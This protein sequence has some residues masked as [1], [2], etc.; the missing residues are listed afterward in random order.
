MSL[1][2]ML[3]ED[4]KKPSITYALVQLSLET[5][6]CHFNKPLTDS[7]DTHPLTLE[8]IS[9][10]EE[11]FGNSYKEYSAILGA[12]PYFDFDS[13][14]LY[15]I[16]NFI[17]DEFDHCCSNSFF[18]E[19]LDSFFPEIMIHKSCQENLLKFLQYFLTIRKDFEEH[20]RYNYLYVY[21]LERSC[22]QVSLA[23]EACHGMF[24]E[25]IV[26][27]N[28]L[29]VVNLEKKDMLELWIKIRTEIKGMSG[30]DLG[31]LECLI[32]VT[33]SFDGLYDKYLE[34][35]LLE[36]IKIKDNISCGRYRSLYDSLLTLPQSL[37]SGIVE[38]SLKF[39]STIADVNMQL[40]MMDFL[41]SCF[42]RGISGENWCEA[43]RLFKLLVDTFDMVN[44][45]IKV[46]LQLLVSELI[47]S[48]GFSSAKDATK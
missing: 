31:H 36:L 14:E 1:S 28:P 17:Y 13:S 41:S 20:P 5:G 27:N 15:Q 35:D 43:Y 2:Y 45:E 26:S 47:G 6:I 24:L 23:P 34:E 33:R 44:D 8:R 42:F 32:S 19:Y 21:L 29:V 40:K 22:L 11:T 9:S 38:E 37:R 30:Y 18:C 25:H 12:L 46:K 7:S 10:F 48:H 4:I 16:M 39:A 3:S